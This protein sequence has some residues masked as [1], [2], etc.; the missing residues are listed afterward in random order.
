MSVK[1]TFW[2]FFLCLILSSW[3]SALAQGMFYH[4]NED[5]TVSDDVSYIPHYEGDSLERSRFLM[6]TKDANPAGKSMKLRESFRYLEDMNSGKVENYGY[7]DW[8]MPTYAQMDHHLGLKWGFSQPR[9]TRNELPK[10]HPFT[11]FYTNFIYWSQA[12]L[13]HLDLTSLF[14][15]KHYL[16]PVRVCGWEGCTRD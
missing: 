3:T 16:W 15:G 9:E 2:G 10:D 11:H 1:T 8:R 14:S 7:T 6:W 4:D 5:G 13:G 12:Q